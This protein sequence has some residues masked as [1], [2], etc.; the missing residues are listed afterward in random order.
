M[1]ESRIWR[2]KTIVNGWFPKLSPD[3]TKVVCGFWN[4]SV[5][6]LVTGQEFEI[7][8]PTGARMN[9]AGWLDNNTIIAHT[10]A[11]PA[12]VYRIDVSNPVPVALNVDGTANWSDCKDGRWALS[13]TNRPYLLVNGAPFHK[14]IPQYGAPKVAGPFLL[15]AHGKTFNLLQFNGDQLVRELPSDNKWSVNA[16]GDVA[17]GYFSRVRL[18]PWGQG[19]I[20]ATLSKVG[21]E[22][23][24]ALIRVNGE[25]WLWSAI[26]DNGSSIIGR[27]L[28]EQDPI[29]LTN[30]P[31][32]DIEG[33][34]DGN[35]FILAGNNTDGSMQVRWVAATAA[36]TKL[37]APAPPTPHPVPPPVPPAPPAPKE[38]P[39]N[40]SF[41]NHLDTLNSVRAKYPAKVTPDEAVAILNE[42]AWTHRDEGFGLL[43]KDGGNH[44]R[45]PKTNV[46]CSC[47]WLVHRGSGLGSDV[48]VDGPD[49]TTSPVTLGTAGTTWGGGAPF[50][51]SKFTEPVNPEIPKPVEVPPVPV[52]PPAPP[53]PD[54]SAESLSVQKECLVELQAIHTELAGIRR[55][56]TNLGEAIKQ[57]GPAVIGALAASSAV[58]GKTSGLGNLLGGL[59]GG[60]K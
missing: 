56:L 22:G 14:D 46:F 45:Q 23:V 27:R 41:P 42:V 20:D 2:P 55:D 9:P 37:I 24:P 35:Q 40:M 3:G 5:A 34:W 1:S 43:R 17:T 8:A 48:L 57:Y 47:D 18:Y 58:D 4:T 33:M 6:N 13:V 28:G 44:G 7:K 26:E 50:D 32:T 30:F 19:V 54:R 12:N 49:G 59:F 39:N 16:Q 21:H 10:E 38:E 52:T 60:K 25:L 29:L 36:R 53:V 51:K 15:I 11:G 31:A